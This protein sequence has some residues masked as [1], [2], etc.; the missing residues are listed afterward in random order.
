MRFLMGLNIEEVSHVLG[1]PGN[2]VKADAPRSFAHGGK[3]GFLMLAIVHLILSALPD[4]YWPPIDL[5]GAL[6]RRKRRRALERAR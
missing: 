2:T 1:M 5:P 6:F 4:S 3:K